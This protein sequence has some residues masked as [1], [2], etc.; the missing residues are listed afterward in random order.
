MGGKEE[1]CRNPGSFTD[2]LDRPISSALKRCP[3]ED[4][5]GGLGP[6]YVGD[7]WR[8]GTFRRGPVGPHSSFYRSN[9]LYAGNTSYSVI[10]SRFCKSY[11]EGRGSVSEMCSF[12]IRIHQLITAPG[13]RCPVLLVENF[14]KSNCLFVDGLMLGR[15]VEKVGRGLLMML[16]LE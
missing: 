15:V 6:G 8:N 1:F 5:R 16:R 13:S 14:L 4:L 2:W 11:T 9:I 10:T 12:Q 3:S 7:S